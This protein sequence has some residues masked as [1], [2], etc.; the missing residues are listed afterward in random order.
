MALK[1]ARLTL[2]IDPNKKAAFEHLCAKQ[3]RTAS[4][5]VRQLIRDYLVEHGVEFAANGANSAVEVDGE[6]SDTIAPP[7]SRQHLKR[8]S[9]SGAKPVANRVSSRSGDIAR[10]S[11][12]TSFTASLTAWAASGSFR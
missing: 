2:L 9:G 12:S 8:K 6:T 1:T 10:F 4:Q 3:D 11:F 7:R 5:I